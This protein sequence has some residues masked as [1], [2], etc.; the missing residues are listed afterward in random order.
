MKL[1]NSNFLYIVNLG[2]IIILI[3]NYKF[4]INY[5]LID[6]KKL[7]SKKKIQHV[8]KIKSR[9]LIICFGNDKDTHLLNLKGN[10]ICE[11]SDKNYFKMLENKIDS[12]LLNTDNFPFFNDKIFS[13][14]LKIIIE[15]NND[16]IILNKKIT[17]KVLFEIIDILKETNIQLILLVPNDYKS[18][19]YLPFYGTV[20]NYIETNNLNSIFFNES[21][22]IKNKISKIPQKLVFN[23][24]GYNHE[25]NI[26]KVI[27]KYKEISHLKINCEGYINL[28]DLK[29]NFLKLKK[30]YKNKIYNVQIYR[31]SW[32]R[33]DDDY[34]VWLSISS[35]DFSHLILQL[36]LVESQRNNL[37]TKKANLAEENLKLGIKVI[38]INQKNYKINS[39]LLDENIMC[40]IKM[41]F[42]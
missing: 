36:T 33:I 18:N 21:N 14:K 7:K 13:Y 30:L 22:K 41:G 11:L 8:Q 2:M 35:P 24:I 23:L 1:L 42:N 5:Y 40:Q 39:H 32:I 16:N 12:N 31:I 20:I 19:L 26:Q 37:T 27:K 4:F 38:N 9:K 15:Q 29:T 10:Y 25:E 6:N 28:I 3:K 34:L 17:D